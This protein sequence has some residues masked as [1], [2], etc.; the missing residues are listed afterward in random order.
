MNPARFAAVVAAR[1]LS[2]SVLSPAEIRSQA[3][4][5]SWNTALVLGLQVALVAVAVALDIMA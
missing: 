1:G 5:Y 3:R 4:H 2:Y